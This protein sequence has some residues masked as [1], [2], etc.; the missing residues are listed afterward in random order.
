[1]SCYEWWWRNAA[2]FGP[3]I[4]FCSRVKFG[5]I[6]LFFLLLIWWMIEF[7]VQTV[8]LNLWYP[9]CNYLISSVYA[10]G[11]IYYTWNLH[12]G[13][14]RV[15]KGPGA[16]KW[17]LKGPLTLSLCL[18]FNHFSYRKTYSNWAEILCLTV[19]CKP[20]PKKKKPKKYFFWEETSW[21]PFHIF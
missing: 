8:T 7:M 6:R 12:S 21:P 11:L 18:Q 3:E 16:P 20:P 9:G 19:S 14:F 1:M 10:E 2:V 13:S 5:P 4:W 15:H 17:R